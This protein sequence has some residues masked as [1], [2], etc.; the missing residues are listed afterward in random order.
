MGMKKVFQKAATT[1]FKIAG[2]IP[3]SATYILE[4]DNGFDEATTEENSCQI[5]YDKFTA[6]DLEHLGWTLIFKRKDIK[7]LVPSLSISVPIGN[8]GKI[9]GDDGQIYDIVEKEIDAADALY[10]LLLRKV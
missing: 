8:K 1:A 2:D 9:K 7:G 6:R 5:I 3:R 4:T 10:L